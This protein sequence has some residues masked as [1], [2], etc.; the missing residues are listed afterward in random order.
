MPHY[1]FDLHNGTGLTADDEGLELAD[2]EAARASAI[3]SI[4]S[5]LSSE[6]REGRIDLRGHIT[7][8]QGSSGATM[9][10]PFSDAVHVI[11]AGS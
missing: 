8:R 5:L 4:R 9:Q 1:F 10:V 3:T 11:A 2:E 7:I 6:V